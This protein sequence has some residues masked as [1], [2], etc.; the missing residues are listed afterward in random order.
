MRKINNPHSRGEVA[1]TCKDDF[2]LFV[3]VD[4]ISVKND[5]ATVVTKLSK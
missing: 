3:N 5:V 2:V 1:I 4:G